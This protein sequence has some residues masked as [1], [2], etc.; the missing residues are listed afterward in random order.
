[1]S[2]ARDHEELLSFLLGQIVK[3]RVC[4]HQLRRHEQPESVKV[5]DTDLDER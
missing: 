3:E 1:L 4:M 5:N 2:Q